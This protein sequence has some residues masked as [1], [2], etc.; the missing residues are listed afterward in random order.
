[1]Y[2]TV[3]E[4]ENSDRCHGACLSHELYMKFQHLETE[5]KESGVQGHSCLHKLKEKAK[6]VVWFS[7]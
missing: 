2:E 4:K 6:E 7:G 5:A 3:K 1:M